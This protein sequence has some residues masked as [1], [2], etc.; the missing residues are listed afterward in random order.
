MENK[1]ISNYSRNEY[2]QNGEDG[3]IEYILNKLP[4][5]DNW[6][7]EFGAVDGIY[8]SNTFNLI[9]NKKYKAV[10]IEANKNK[11]KELR[12]NLSHF[13][14]LL[15]NKFIN[16]E[17]TDSL[18][19]TLAKTPITKDF[20]FLSID[21]DGNDYWIFESLQYYKPKLICIEYNPSIPNDEDYIQKRDF[22]ISRGSSAKSIVNLATE[23]KYHLISTTYSN[24]FFIHSDYY[25]LFNELNN[26]L[27]NLRDDNSIRIYA[28]VGYDGTIIYS[29]PLKLIWHNFIVEK[30][31]LQIIPS[32]IRKHPPDY[33]LIEKFIFFI[34]LF[35]RKPIEAIKRA[36]KV[37]KRLI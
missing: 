8:L 10:L 23:K 7:V 28:Y 12:K 15:I 33:N 34:F 19:N 1:L 29:K 22:T 25:Y 18:D 9:K 21:I 11:Y 16:F 2:S 3:I 14:C 37:M 6:C 20:D 5:R 27:N 17:G 30:D 36:I 26:K 35:K 13:D 31:E 4:I 24:L 32:I